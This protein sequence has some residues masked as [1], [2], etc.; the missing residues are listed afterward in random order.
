MW[1]V[2]LR[3]AI[4]VY[5]T[6]LYRHAYQH[7]TADL[8]YTAGGCLLVQSFTARMPLLKAN[9]ALGLG[10]KRW[11]SPQQ[12][13]LRCLRTYKNILHVNKLSPR[14]R[15]DDMPPAPADSSSTRGGS[16]SVR[17]RVRSPHI[18]G[19]QPA[20]GSQRADSL[21]TGRGAAAPRSQR[22]IA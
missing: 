22:A 2:R 14:A 15:R 10:R 20:A 7:K 6:L 16:T 1:Q 18:S 21:G 9:R 3:T 4:S 19:G 12:C 5:F 17:G 13:Y 8:R 11:S